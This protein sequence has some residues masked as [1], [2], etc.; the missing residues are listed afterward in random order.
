ME[1]ATP[2]CRLVQQERHRLGRPKL[3]AVRRVVAMA[4]D[5]EPE[6][7][8]ILRAMRHVEEVSYRVGGGPSCRELAS[9][10]AALADA[11][12]TSVITDRTTGEAAERLQ[13][14]LDENRQTPL[15]VDFNGEFV[16]RWFHPR[17]ASRL[18]QVEMYPLRLRLVDFEIGY[19]EHG[20]ETAL[21]EVER[22]RALRSTPMPED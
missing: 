5:V 4:G 15:Q 14:F 11:G 19:L 22:Q 10:P 7:R 12:W 13:R 17:V 21:A 16:R 3:W 6:V 20:K 1:D 8:D 2:G 18:I 9:L